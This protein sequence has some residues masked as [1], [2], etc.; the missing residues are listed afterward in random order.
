MK[1]KIKHTIT[2]FI[3]STALVASIG[4][5]TGLSAWAMEEGTRGGG[6]VV[7]LKGGI[8]ELRDLVDKTN[9]DWK[10]GDEILK[11]APAISNI[12]Q[13]VSEIDW[14]V[15]FNFERE[16]RNLGWCFTSELIKLN[17]DDADALTSHYDYDSTQAAIRILDAEEVYVD[18]TVFDEKLTPR[19]KAFLIIHEMLHSF[20]KK[21]Q[22]LRNTRL[23]S[24]VKTIE[25]VA[26]GIIDS[27]DKFDF[28]VKM[29]AITLPLQTQTLDPFKDFVLY[30]LGSNATRK[31]VLRRTVDVDALFAE[32][33]HSAEFVAALAAQDQTTM[34]TF[35]AKDSIREI[36][37]LESQKQSP[38]SPDS[39][40]NALLAKTNLSKETLMACLDGASS[41][42]TLKN[43]ILLSPGFLGSIDL[44]FTQMSQKSFSIKD[45]RIVVPSVVAMMTVTEPAQDT[46]PFT[47]LD[48][49]M[50]MNWNKLNSQ[51]VGFYNYVKMLIENDAWTELSSRIAQNPVFYKAFSFDSLKAQ[52]PDV[53]SP[54]TLE[55]EL[56]SEMVNEIPSRFWNLFFSKLSIDV[57]TDKADRL[58]S[59]LDMGKLIG[60]G[61]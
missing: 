22:S 9:C 44:I 53:Q 43:K 41:N 55:K 30:A 39:L 49:V 26:D 36:C 13:K 7:N 58:H 25:R 1:T 24:M 8:S 32:S 34:Q 57:G 51:G 3:A 33:K 38:D 29:N 14:Y 18:S 37:L 48:P 4:I 61:K 42:A 40:V 17:V 56:A 46:V 6:Q 12:L 60:S 54:V 11:S 10:S 35:S 2:A 15:A 59:M 21:D 47:S 16:I 27:R 19:T 23:R 28:Q 31:D 50:N 5:C 20:I 52:L 45:Q